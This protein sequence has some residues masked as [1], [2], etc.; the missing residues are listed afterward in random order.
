[1]ETHPTDDEITLRIQVDPATGGIVLQPFVDRWA[2]RERA[3]AKEQRAQRARA[4]VVLVSGVALA[5][6]LAHFLAA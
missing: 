6:W 4:I 5:A 2:Q 1:M 3:M